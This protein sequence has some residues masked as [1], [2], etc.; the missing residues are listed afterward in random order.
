MSVRKWRNE[1]SDYN[2]KKKYD[3]FGLFDDW[4]FI[5]TPSYK[6]KLFMKL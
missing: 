1:N 3:I 5:P 4:I 2:N 6:K